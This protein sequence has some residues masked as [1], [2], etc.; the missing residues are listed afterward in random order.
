VDRLLCQWG[1]DKAG[2]PAVALAWGANY[3][4]PG[5]WGNTGEAV[6]DV[7]RRPGMSEMKLWAGGGN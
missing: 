2:A 5:K 4:P 3:F 1:K 6:L 7:G